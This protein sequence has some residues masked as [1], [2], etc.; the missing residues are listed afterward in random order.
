[1]ER[2]HVVCLVFYWSFSK[3]HFK[4]IEKVL[5]PRFLIWS[6]KEP[7]ACTE[8]PRRHDIFQVKLTTEG[9]SGKW[10]DSQR[11]AELTNVGYYRKSLALLRKP[12]VIDR[13]APAGHFWDGCHGDFVWTPEHIISHGKPWWKCTCCFT[14]HWSPVALDIFG[15]THNWTGTRP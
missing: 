9:N 14:R 13:W 1:M 8:K 7:A 12:A 2:A 15:T 4:L 11:T 3:E 6:L 5:F 10:G